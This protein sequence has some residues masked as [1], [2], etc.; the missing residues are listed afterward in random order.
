MLYILSPIN[1]FQI[2][3]N[4]FNKKILKD[5]NFIMFYLR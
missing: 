1:I 4:L 5:V 2:S 3:D